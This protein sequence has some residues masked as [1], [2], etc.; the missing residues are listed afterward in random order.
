MN[1]SSLLL[2]FLTFNILL[3]PLTGKAQQYEISYSLT[4]KFNG[5]QNRIEYQQLISNKKSYALYRAGA[6]NSPENARN[7]DFSDPNPNSYVIYLPQEKSITYT[8]FIQSEIFIVQ[9]QTPLFTWK[10]KEGTRL[11][12]GQSCDEFKVS[13]RGRDYT[14]WVTTDLGVIGGVWKFVGLPGYVMAAYSDDGEVAY[15][16]EALQITEQSIPNLDNFVK[17]DF[18]KITS[19]EEYTKEWLETNK[20]LEKYFQAESDD[21]VEL[22]HQ[23]FSVEIIK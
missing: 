12:Q 2:I 18:T 20:K 16:V 13:F 1:N 15:E 3:L 23:I 8:A 10:K 11:V 14:L 22:S 19:W 5:E 9:E 7:V 21:E 4:T 17:K 6:N